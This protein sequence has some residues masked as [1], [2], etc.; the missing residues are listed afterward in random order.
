[1]WPKL[2]HALPRCPGFR[3]GGRTGQ[4]KA[5]LYSGQREL[6]DEGPSGGRDWLPPRTP[7]W[8]RTSAWLQAPAGPGQR[9]TH[10]AGPFPESPPRR[11]HL[12]QI[13]LTET[14]PGSKVIS[15]NPNG[16][17]PAT[18]QMAACVMSVHGE[19]HFPALCAGI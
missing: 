13:L 9:G 19:A 6:Q 18:H 16:L 5:P 8:S 3:A 11:Q 15:E 10:G 4:P 2:A 17:S 7:T 12:E 14:C 1:M